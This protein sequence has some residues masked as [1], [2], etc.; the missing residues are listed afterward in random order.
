MNEHGC[1]YARSCMYLIAFMQTSVT[2]VSCDHQ[3]LCELTEVLPS[4]DVDPDNGLNVCRRVWIAK[5]DTVQT[6]R[7]LADRFV[8]SFHIM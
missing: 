6:N 4:A 3:A 2:C 1:T 8:T 7:E 5:H